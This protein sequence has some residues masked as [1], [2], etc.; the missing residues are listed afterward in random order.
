MNQDISC[1]ILLI[2]GELSGDLYGHL[3]IKRIR[4]INPAFHF[5]GIGGPRIRSLGIEVLFSSESLSLVG[6]PSLRD[7]KNTGLFIKK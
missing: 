1:R 7:L 2:T 6:L 5:L 3:L 4:D